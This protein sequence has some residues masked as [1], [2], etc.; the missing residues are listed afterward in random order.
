MFWAVVTTRG[1]VLARCETER[2]ALSCCWS[3]SL[4]PTKSSNHLDAAA[5]NLDWTAEPATATLCER[6]A[7]ELASE[8]QLP[9]EHVATRAA[10]LTVWCATAGFV[11]Q[12]L[13]RT[14]LRR[15]R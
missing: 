15:L 6:P 9:R 7:Q 12:P 13:P 2:V 4:L 11:I 8:S 14:A 10:F 3:Y 5:D 1:L